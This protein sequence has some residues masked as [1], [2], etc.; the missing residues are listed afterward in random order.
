MFVIHKIYIIN[1]RVILSF[2]NIW[3]SF[4][5]NI[6]FW[7]KR[8]DQRIINIWHELQTGECEFY[9]SESKSIENIWNIQIKTT[10]PNKYED[11]TLPLNAVIFNDFSAHLRQYFNDKFT[12]IYFQLL[13]ILRIVRMNM[14]FHISQ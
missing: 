13:K 10:F 3:N 14:F 9:A 2:S 4:N 1:E 7:N 8:C 12:N 11:W 6:H 5:F